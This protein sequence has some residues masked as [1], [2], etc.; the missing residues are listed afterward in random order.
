M[1]YSYAG[2]D[3]LDANFNRLSFVSYFPTP[4]VINLTNEITFEPPA[5]LNIINETTFSINNQ[6]YKVAKSYLIKTFKVGD[7]LSTTI[8]VDL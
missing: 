7:K 3:D 6:I 2:H 4:N 5:T 8:F 1:D